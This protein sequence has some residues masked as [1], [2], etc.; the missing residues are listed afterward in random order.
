MLDIFGSMGVSQI[1]IG[2]TIIDVPKPKSRKTLKGYGNTI[3]VGDVV[4][5]TIDGWTDGPVRMDFI[6]LNDKSIRFTESNGSQ[7]SALY[8]HGSWRRTFKK[9]D[10]ATTKKL[11]DALKYEGLNV[12][13]SL[14][15]NT[16][17]TNGTYYKGT[18]YIPACW[19]AWCGDLQ[20]AFSEYRSPYGKLKKKNIVSWVKSKMYQGAVAVDI[21]EDFPVKL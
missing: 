14:D 15:F 21:P 12:R 19:I 3:K 6:G 1:K 2:S 13:L 4:F 16:P 5:I 20:K 10:K 7:P 18:C 11:N 8:A 9:A 17:K